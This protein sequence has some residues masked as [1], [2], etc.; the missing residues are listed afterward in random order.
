MAAMLNAVAI[1]L[2]M[3]VPQNFR[4]ES[5]RLTS[6]VNRGRSVVVLRNVRPDAAAIL[7]LPVG[8]EAAAHACLIAAELAL[9]VVGAVEMI[10]APPQDLRAP[11][12]FQRP[13]ANIFQHH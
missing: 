10:I 8:A 3:L 1:F 9:E 12:P 2:I 13:V 7:A 11:H 6:P 5:D 4:P